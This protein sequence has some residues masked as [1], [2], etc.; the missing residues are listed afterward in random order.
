ML[1]QILHSNN[2]SNRCP[3]F[4]RSCLERKKKK[5]HCLLAVLQITKK[6]KSSVNIQKRNEWWH[7]H[8]ARWLLNVTC[9]PLTKLTVKIVRHEC[10]EWNQARVPLSML[11]RGKKKITIFSKTTQ[12][13]SLQ[14]LFMCFVKMTAEIM[15]KYFQQEVTGVWLQHDQ[16]PASL[17][18]D[19]FG[20]QI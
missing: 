15:Q 13:Q 11:L 12:I 5:L 14:S 6:R 3:L 10:T 7:L 16:I 2:L 20:L 1:C 4:C 18:C 17:V 19:C 9:H 8:S